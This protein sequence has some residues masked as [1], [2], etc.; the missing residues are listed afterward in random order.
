MQSYAPQPA[1]GVARAG[2]LAVP[3]SVTC[4]QAP[5]SHAAPTPGPQAPHLG[6]R[7]LPRRWRK[8]GQKIVKGNPHPRSYY[9][10]TMAGCP[11]RKHV[12]RSPS[13]AGVLLT[14]YEGAHNHPQPPPSL[15]S[16]GRAFSRRITHLVRALSGVAEHLRCR[17]ALLHRHRAGMLLRCLIWPQQGNDG[18][19]SPALL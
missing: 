19:F 15:P 3:A 9:K 6:A 7:P 16:H 4:R 12:E 18:P 1:V 2:L 11:V 14:T 8:Y 10:C 5:A 13:A 17:P